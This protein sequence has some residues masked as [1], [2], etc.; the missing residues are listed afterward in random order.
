MQRHYRYADRAATVARGAT[1]GARA[2]SNGG[3]HDV[4]RRIQEFLAG[5]AYAVA[6]ASN[7][8]RKFGNQVLRSYLAAGRRAYPIHP[9]L[10][11]VEG[12]KA[13]K[14]LE[15]LPERVHG[16]SI[17]TPS[18]VTERLVEEAAAAGIPRVW[19]QP[20]AESRRALELADELGIDAIAGG[21]CVLVELGFPD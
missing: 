6:G 2:C 18:V 17:I 19:M 8:R 5:E 13:Y 14:R 15:D 3:V 10:E 1:P 7:D 11:E 12:Q 20:G 9:L 21:P 4:R 16:L